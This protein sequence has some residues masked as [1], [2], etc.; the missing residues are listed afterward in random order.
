MSKYADNVI[1][2]SQKENN[3]AKTV[4]EKI[5]EIMKKSEEQRNST[6]FFPVILLKNLDQITNSEEIGTG[7][8]KESVELNVYLP[9]FIFIVT[10]ST[11]NSKLAPDLQAKLKPVEPFFDKYF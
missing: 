1:D 8:H 6:E 7:T 4:E 5:L 2:F 11:S 3:Q 9:Q 10:T